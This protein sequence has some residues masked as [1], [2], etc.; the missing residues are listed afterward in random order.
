MPDEVIGA[1]KRSGGAYA[2]PLFSCG[3]YFAA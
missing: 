3:I 1:S 2:L